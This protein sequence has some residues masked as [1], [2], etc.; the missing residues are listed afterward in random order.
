MFTPRQCLA[1]I[2]AMLTIC[3]IVGYA[4][5]LYTAGRFGYG[6]QQVATSIELTCPPRLDCPEERRILG[7]MP[8]AAR[9]R[10]MRELSAW[11]EKNGDAQ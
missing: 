9:A 4:A 1:I 5:G 3:L 2:G 8:P 11:A 7:M 6:A 10:E